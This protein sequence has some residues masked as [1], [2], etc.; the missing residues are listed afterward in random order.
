MILEVL[1]RCSLSSAAREE[2]QKCF[3]AARV[4]QLRVC[5]CLSVCVCVCVCVC[6]SVSM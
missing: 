5:A 2:L 3:P 6:V 1:D 4:A